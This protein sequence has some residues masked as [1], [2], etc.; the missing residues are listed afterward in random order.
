M[1]RSGWYADLHPDGATL[2]AR[3]A[4]RPSSA[5]TP[6][7]PASSCTSCRP[8]GSD[9]ESLFFQL[10]SPEYVGHAPGSAEPVQQPMT[11]NE[12]VGR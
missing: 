11:M 9:L 2:V 3:R 12:E 6:S 10:V 4:R 5:T 1:Q 7:P 8:I